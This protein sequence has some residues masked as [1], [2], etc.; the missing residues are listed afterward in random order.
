MINITHYGAGDLEIIIYNEE[1][2]TKAGL[3]T[4]L[5]L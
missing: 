4:L 5:Q 3:L 1:D 2:L